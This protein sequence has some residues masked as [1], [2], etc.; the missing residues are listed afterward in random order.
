MR[1]QRCYAR[2]HS[3]KSTTS[4]PRARTRHT[5]HTPHTKERA[6]TRMMF[7]LF[8]SRPFRHHIYR[9]TSL[10]LGRKFARRWSLGTTQGP[11][12]RQDSTA[13]DRIMCTCRW[14]G[15]TPRCTGCR[16]RPH[17]LEVLRWI[18][19]R[20]AEGVCVKKAKEGARRR[21]RGLCACGCGCGCV[22]GEGVSESERE[23][24]SGRHYR[25]KQSERPRT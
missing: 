9:C 25:S 4:T 16:R 19:V 6:C 7:C 14:T 12:S 5:P 21:E 23:E 1:R 13:R 18:V 20:G 10:S 11:N 2:P 24:E 22:W 15:N 17:S 3:V 8:A